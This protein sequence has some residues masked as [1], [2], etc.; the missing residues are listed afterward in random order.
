VALRTFV[1]V[2]LLHNDLIEI[3]S[4]ASIAIKIDAIHFPMHLIVFQGTH[5]FE[6]FPRIV[7]YIVV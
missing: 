2:D 3:Q 4:Y 6:D 7:C 5:F 1:C